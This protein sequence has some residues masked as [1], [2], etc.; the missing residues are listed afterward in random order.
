LQL[1]KKIV[2]LFFNLSFLD[3]LENTINLQG[4]KA[5]SLLIQLDEGKT[6]PEFLGKIVYALKEA[7]IGTNSYKLIVK[8][9]KKTPNNTKLWDYEEQTN[10]KIK[11][12]AEFENVVKTYSLS[13][14]KMIAKF[15]IMTKIFEHTSK[16]KETAGTINKKLD[17]Y[18]QKVFNASLKNLQH[19]ESK[20]LIKKGN[21]LYNQY[22]QKFEK[23][24]IE[25]NKHSLGG[26]GSS[27]NNPATTCLQ[28]K[29]ISKS[30]LTGF[31][32]IKPECSKSVHKVWCDFSVYKSSLDI[33]VYSGESSNLNPDLTDWKL[34]TPEDIGYYCATIGLRPLEIKNK[35]ILSR[36]IDL[37]KYLGYDLNLPQVIPLGY[38]YSCNS[39]KGCSRKFHSFTGKNSHLIN[40]FFMNDKS[41]DNYKAPMV[42][43][44][45]GKYDSM[46]VF[47]PKKTIISG[48]VCSSNQYEQSKSKAPNFVD[49]ETTL[50]ASGDTF[51]KNTEKLIEC[52]INCGSAKAPLYGSE[53][54]DGKSS[55]CK[56]AVHSGKIGAEGGKVKIKVND[57]NK[58]TTLNSTNNGVTS[59][60]NPSIDGSLSFSFEKY[61]PDCPIQEYVQ[62]AKEHNSSFLELSSTTNLQ[63]GTTTKLKLNQ[64]DFEGI[65]EDNLRQAGIFFKDDKAF[66]DQSKSYRFANKNNSEEYNRYNEYRGFN[67][68]IDTQKLGGAIGGLKDFGKGLAGKTKKDGDK[69]MKNLNNNINH[70]VQNTAGALNNHLSDATNGLK[71]MV[72]NLTE[73]SKVEEKQQ[74]ELLDKEEEKNKPKDNYG[75]VNKKKPEQKVPEPPEDPEIIEEE[76]PKHDPSIDCSP[77]TNTGVAL[78]ESMFEDNFKTRFSNVE[79]QIKKINKD[80]KDFKNQFSWSDEGNELSNSSLFSKLG[81]IRNLSNK[82]AKENSIL[83]KKANRRK[84]HTESV[85]KKWLDKLINLKKYES[86]KINYKNTIEALFEI[87]N[88]KFVEKEGVEIPKWKTYKENIK[89]RKSAVG[90]LGPVKPRK[91]EIG[92]TILLKNK[93]VYDFVFEVDLLTTSLAGQIGLVFRWQNKFTYYALIIDLD[94][95]SKRVVRVKQGDSHTLYEIK[96]GGILV[97]NWHRFQVHLMTDSIK[98][99]YYDL[100]SK[101]GKGSILVQDGAIARGK[102]GMFSTESNSFYFDNAVLESYPC[103]SPWSPR[104]N[105]KIITNT[106]NFYEENYIG[107][108]TNKYIIID[109][110]NSENSPS[111]WKFNISNS[112]SWGDSIEQ[113]SNIS[114]KSNNKE[115]SKIIHKNLNFSN[116]NFKTS[117]IAQS[118]NGVVSIIFK[119]NSMKLPDGS[120]KA[121]YYTFDLHNSK[122]GNVYILRKY[123]NKE[124]RILKIVNESPKSAPSSFKVGYDKNIK[125]EVTIV[126][127]DTAIQALVSYNDLIPVTVLE[128]SDEH[129][130]KSGLVG[131]GTFGTAVSFYKFNTYGFKVTISP[132]QI[133]KF[134]KS[135]TQKPLTT[136]TIDQIENKDKVDPEKEE[137]DIDGENAKNIGTGSPENCHDDKKQIKESNV[138]TCVLNNTYDL[139]KAYCK[140]TLPL[141][142]S[143]D[144]VVSFILIFRKITVT[145][146]VKIKIQK[147]QMV[148]IFVPSL[149]VSL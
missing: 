58:D 97:N 144:C 136:E 100:E 119:Y 35:Q 18:E 5:S 133:D 85:Y 140:S 26:L 44:G 31:Y 104:K 59:E 63:T 126:C 75:P 91:G 11:K 95:K 118:N 130:F 72:D 93:E 25:E 96:D 94:R 79:N 145:Y 99:E 125:V 77:S 38:D 54:Y 110:E 115:S 121:S 28:I 61:E 65:D 147:I 87:H 138:G 48:I 113:K 49:C 66:F 2:R 107:Q 105:L 23:K 1:L 17:E 4:I 3:T 109:P 146:V 37:I 84:F 114:D 21:N 16:A 69:F 13:L 6:Y 143:S 64:E 71:G 41:D 27:E 10:T 47:D 89:G 67:K 53:L 102:I 141:M 80:I 111:D 57:K 36:T 51:K 55:I 101:T 52:D 129:Y 30:A 122:V 124:F 108:I 33:L 8:D 134:I 90:F 39:N 19:F 88:M 78:I 139:R 83:I 42:G 7:F 24:K 29:K 73:A 50:N 82:V 106:T 15:R 56:A 43:I 70:A 92:S 62:K 76:P 148:Y 9:C 132:N 32:W 117:F 12:T 128:Y 112:P 142:K 131:V 34:Y 116:G 127:Q 60:R 22:Y 74:Q 40:N 98:I 68:G 86:F 149:A 137:K 45:Y 14:E 46:K 135:S 120:Y 123:E 20:E 81:K 103:W